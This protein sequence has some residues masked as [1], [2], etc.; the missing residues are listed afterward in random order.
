MAGM[1]GWKVLGDQ[2]TQTTTLKKG[3]GGIADVYEVPYQITDGPAAGHTGTVTIDAAAF[4]PQ[5][6][7]EAVAAQVSAVHDVAQLSG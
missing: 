7:S 1:P 4:N 2:I 3:G 5:N 6:V